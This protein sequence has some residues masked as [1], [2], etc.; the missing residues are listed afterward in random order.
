RLLVVELDGLRPLLADRDGVLQ[1]R[2]AVEVVELERVGV[3][4]HE[5]ALRLDRLDRPASG[6][7]RRGAAAFED[8]PARAA[9]AALGYRLLR[10]QPHV[11]A[12]RQLGAVGELVLDGAANR[13]LVPTALA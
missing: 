12:G 10:Q 11:L 9:G 1:R 13:V 7:D 2:R 3:V 4:R 6:P 8:R 5:G